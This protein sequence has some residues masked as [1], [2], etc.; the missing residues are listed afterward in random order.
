[1]SIIKKSFPEDYS[2]AYIKIINAMS[3]NPKNIFIE[4]TFSIK[5]ML[6]PADID[7][8]EKVETKYKTVSES[9]NY[10][11]KQYKQIVSNLSKLSNIYVGYTMAGLVNDKPLKW[12]LTDV[13]EGENKGYTLEDAFLS[14]SIFKLDVIALIDGIYTEFSNTYQFFNKNKL[15]NEYELFKKSSLIDDIERF[16]K[17]KNYYKMAKRI[18]IKDGNKKLIELFNGDAGFLNQICAN[19]ETLIYIFENIK[20][21]PMKN[22]KNEIDNFITRINLLNNTKILNDEHLIIMLKQTENTTDR[23][24]LIKNLSILYNDIDEI[25]QSDSK[26]FLKKLK[27]I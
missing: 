2:N 4:G 25:V 8:F 19:I 27:L 14:P 21:L 26:K 22:I 13:L 17:D 15:I 16:K 7:V 10:L 23:E 20:K 1:M 12:T 11:S 3:F 9:V 5:G 18:F 24:K 6:Y